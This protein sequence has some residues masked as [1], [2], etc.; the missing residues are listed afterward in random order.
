MFCWVPSHI[1]IRGSLL[2][3]CLVSRLVY[4]ILIFKD[5]INQYILSTW[6][7]DWN[8]VVANKLHLSCRSWEID[9]HPTGSARRMNLSCVMPTLV[10]HILKKN[11]PQCEHCWCILT[12]CHILVECSHVDQ[13]MKDIFGRRDV[14]DS[15]PNSFFFFKQ[16]VLY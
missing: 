5:H 8:G 16:S 9:S 11:I 2:W 4:P 15:T 3:I 7:D 1:G 10:I 6:Q 13:K 14:V 12:V